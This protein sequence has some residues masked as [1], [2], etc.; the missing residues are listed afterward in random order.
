MQI[1]SIEI[2]FLQQLI[3]ESAAAINIDFIPS[4]KTRSFKEKFNRKEVF[5]K[6]ETLLIQ[7]GVSR[8]DINLSRTYFEY[9]DDGA[10]IESICQ[11]YHIDDITLMEEINQATGIQ[12]YNISKSQND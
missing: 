3:S 2:P 1:G 9:K 10:F 7:K 11:T 12:L 5:D 6:I 8:V 4:A